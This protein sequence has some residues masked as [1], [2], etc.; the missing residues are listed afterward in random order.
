MTRT[1]HATYVACGSKFSGM[2]VGNGWLPVTPLTWRV[3]LNVSTLICVMMSASHAT[4][5]A[6]GSKLL[7]Q[8]VVIDV[9]SHA[10]YVA[11]GSK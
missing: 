6:C 11:G 9:L 1:G 4:Y 3:G 10:T 7:S 5:V 2:D 8:R